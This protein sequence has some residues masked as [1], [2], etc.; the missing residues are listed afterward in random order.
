MIQSGE[1]TEADFEGSTG[2]SDKAEEKEYRSIAERRVRLGLLLSEVGQARDVQIAAEE[3]NRKIMQ[4]AQQFPGQEKEV[5]EFYQKNENAL[6]QLR[7]PIYEE[8]VC[9]LILGDATVKEKTVTL[10]ALQNLAKTDH[11]LQETQCH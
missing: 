7:A 4:E 2:P 8:K 6:A 1:A 3:V 5:F 9:E 10:E 11:R